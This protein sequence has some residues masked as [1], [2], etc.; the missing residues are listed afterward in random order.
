MGNP[1]VIRLKEMAKEGEE[2]YLK[3]CK[4]VSIDESKRIMECEPL[5]GT[6][7]ILDVRLTASATEEQTDEDKICL[8]PRVNSIVAIGFLDSNEAVLVLASEIDKVE[9]KIGDSVLTIDKNKYH[10]NA[11]K[12]EFKSV[13]D[14]MLRA[15]IFDMANN[16]G[17]SVKSII[18]RFIDEV[19]KIVVVTG[20]S[21]NVGALEA[22]KQDNN[23]L[24]K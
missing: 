19:K 13:E 6:A 16:D 1:L 18:N 20:V 12:I 2:L 7:N 23:K 22:I 3:L 21:P 4:V 8:F 9:I 5:D 24:F 17:I 10:L 11:N 15:S 14:T